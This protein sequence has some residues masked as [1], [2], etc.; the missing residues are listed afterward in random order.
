MAKQ[1]SQKLDQYIESLNMNGLLGRVLQMPAKKKSN[2]KQILLVYGH[3]ASL[4][5]M[6]G[7]AE[8][9]QKYGSV[10]MPDLPGFGG[11]QSFYKINEEPDIDTLADYLA[12]FIKMRYKNRRFTVAGMSFGFV[13]VTR[14]LQKYPEMA[15][16]IDNIISIVGFVHHEDFKLKTHQKL[17]LKMS[18]TLLSKRPIAVLSRYLLLNRPMIH[19]A[20]SVVGDSHSKLKDA[21]ASERKRRIRFE[22]EL[23]QANDL[24]TYAY[25]GREML[26]VN[27]CNGNRQIPLKVTHVSVAEDRYFDNNVV[28][29]HL[30]IVYT[31]VEVVSTTMPAHAPTVVSSAKEAAQ[32][33]PKQL[34]SQLKAA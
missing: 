3:H 24:R 6:Y 33:I 26:R 1:S 4:E 30:N 20:Y 22:V 23:W 18:S 2:N 12:S 16:K 10:T 28:E 34:R 8:E 21:D 32:F 31:D 19:L 13:I 14:M 27:L 25:T 11:M 9:L 15:K 29:Q 5:R 17:L 7:F